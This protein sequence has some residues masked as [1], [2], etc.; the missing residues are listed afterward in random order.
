MSLHF[1]CSVNFV[2]IS[3]GNYKIFY[4]LLIGVVYHGKNLK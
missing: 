3:I 1:V 4:S 2:Q